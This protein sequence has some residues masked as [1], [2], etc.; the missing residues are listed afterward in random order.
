MISAIAARLRALGLHTDAVVG[1]QL[2]NTVES[3]LTILG[4]LRAGMIAAPLP[5]LWR[6]GAAPPCNV[7]WRQGD[8]HGRR[9][10]CARAMRS[11]RSRCFRSATSAASARAARRRDS[12]RR[13]AGRRR[14]RATPGRARRPS[15]RP[16]RAGHLRRHRRRHC[17]GGAQPRRAD[18]RRARRPL[19]EGGIAP[20]ARPARLLAPRLLRRPR[21][22]P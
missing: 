9:G 2:P 6:R 12:V 7:G 14:A 19:L 20:D 18:R 16:C 13:P 22:R 10:S 11:P 17:A 1:V 3:V 21:T 8:R 4:V 15:R 5:L